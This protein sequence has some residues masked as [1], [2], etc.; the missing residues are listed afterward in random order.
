MQCRSCGL[1]GLSYS[2]VMTRKLSVYFK[3]SL[4]NIIVLPICRQCINWIYEDPVKYFKQYRDEHEHGITLFW[5]YSILT[6]L[7]KRK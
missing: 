4:G 3:D 5:K 2:D 7:Q 1:P 6:G